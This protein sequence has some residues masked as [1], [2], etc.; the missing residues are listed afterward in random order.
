[1]VQTAQRG[2]TLIE[3]MIVV[4]IIGILAAVAL[5]AYQDYTKKARFSEVQG[6]A[7]GLKSLVTTCASEDSGSFTN[8]DSG[9]S[10]IPAALAAATTNTATLSVADGVI[11]GAATAAADSITTELRPA[12]NSASSIITWTNAGGCVAKGWCKAN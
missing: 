5:P 3:L 7:E 2:F 8:C 11:S 6:L 12:F 10:G 9:S 1:M 4:A